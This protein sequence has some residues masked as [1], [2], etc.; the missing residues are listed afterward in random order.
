MWIC[1]KCKHKFVISNQSHACDSFALEGFLADK[2][3]KATDLLHAFINTYKKTGI[4]EI[5][6]VKTRIDLYGKTKFGAIAKIGIDFIDGY[7]VFNEIHNDNSCFYK[8][9]SVPGKLFLHHFRLYHKAEINTELIAQMRMAYEISAGHTT[10]KTSPLKKP[11]LPI[12]KPLRRE[13]SN[14]KQF[15]YL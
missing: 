14:T 7:L 1:P 4:L 11:K 13:K 6:P 5:R 12:N 2:S 15:Y 3:D 10:K 8:I 9:E